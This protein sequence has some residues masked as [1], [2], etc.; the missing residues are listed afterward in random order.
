MFAN[1][2]SPIYLLGSKAQQDQKSAKN[3]TAT[4]EISISD[5][6]EKKDNS[7]NSSVAKFKPQQ[8][9]EKT[10][11]GNGKK[12]SEISY[13][14]GEKDG[15]EKIYYKNGQVCSKTEFRNGK[16]E[17][18]R[19]QYYANGKIFSEVSFTN[20][21]ENGIYKTYH[22][23]GK[24]SSEVEYING[25]RNGILKEYDNNGSLIFETPYIKGVIHGVIKFYSLK[26]KTTKYFYKINGKEVSK[27]EW[28][29]FEKSKLLNTK[30]IENANVNQK[31]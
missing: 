15:T 18:P 31:Q 17:G 29:A 24:I 1:G 8:K 16:R 14:N 4:K 23:N 5:K 20:D 3:P 28:E 22:E 9:T 27:E 30:V 6:S 2:C 25:T 7:I 11:Y 13:I 12:F 26:Y 19:T 10:Y 21:K